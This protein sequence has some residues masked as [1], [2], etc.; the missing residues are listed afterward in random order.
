MGSRRPNHSGISIV[1]V[2]AVL[3]G[4]AFELV[5]FAFGG[6]TVLENSFAI[7]GLCGGRNWQTALSGH[8]RGVGSALAFIPLSS[9][10]NGPDPRVA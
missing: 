2:F 10:M 5:T 9:F 1:Y 4:P 3:F 8:M 6:Q 7:S